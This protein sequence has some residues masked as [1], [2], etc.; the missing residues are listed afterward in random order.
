MR[1]EEARRGEVNGIPYTLYRKK[2]KNINLR[3]APD[4]SVRVSAPARVSTAR[5]EAFL[6]SKAGWIAQNR[7]RALQTQAKRQQPFPYTK[8]QC[9]A[10]FMPVLRQYFGLFAEVLNGQMPAL[11]V[12]MMKTR[13]GVCA[14]Q[15]RRITLNM[16]L[17]LA[18]R[19]A[20]EYVVLHEYVHFLYPDHQAGFHA[21]MRR[22]MPDYKRRAALLREV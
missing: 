19:E 8:A 15:K 10:L 7:S 4:G 14:V 3:I 20:L 9:E 1:Q 5:I 2:V 11:Q 13:W 6:C 21:A 16:R 18:P 12:R 17:A 22:C